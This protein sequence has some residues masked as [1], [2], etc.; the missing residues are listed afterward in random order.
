MWRR[1][2]RSTNLFFFLCNVGLLLWYR[3][4]CINY[5][6]NSRWLPC[7]EHTSYIE[8]TYKYNNNLWWISSCSSCFAWVRKCQ[9]FL[10]LDTSC[11]EFGCWIWQP[12]DILLR[13]PRRSER[14]SVSLFAL[15]AQ[16]GRMLETAG[17]H[18]LPLGSCAAVS[19]CSR[20]WAAA[21][22]ADHTLARIFCGAIRQRE[23]RKYQAGIMRSAGVCFLSPLVSTQALTLCFW[24]KAEFESILSL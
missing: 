2:E 6:F 12:F 7:R 15:S 14:V 19:G 1:S 22:D 11:T 8:E 17:L 18:V 3:E 4:L 13:A 21:R 23:F 10:R 5:H 9:H 20:C 16:R 24:D